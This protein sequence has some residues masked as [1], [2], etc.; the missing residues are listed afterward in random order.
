MISVKV[1]GI[2]EAI[3][4]LNEFDMDTVCYE[5]ASTLKVDIGHRVHVEGKAADGSKIGTYSKGYMKVRTGNYEE[6]RLKSGK[7]KGKFRKKKQDGQAGVF[8]KGP[9]KG[10]K[11]PVYNRGGEREVILSLTRQM[12][13]DL[14]NTEPIKIDGGYGIG[15]SNEH[16]YNK[17]VWNE[18]RYGKSIWNLTPDEK[19]TAEEIVKKHIRKIND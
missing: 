13:N 1:S 14:N 19:E 6:T 17:A 12:E 8:T 11:R 16:N 9:R 3:S 4:S 18:K 7:N 10:Q 2:D 5:I 15:Y